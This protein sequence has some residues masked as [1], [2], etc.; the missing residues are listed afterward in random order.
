[1]LAAAGC[2]CAPSAPP[3][4][5]PQPP[6][7]ALLLVLDTT[8]D[9][10]L[11]EVQTPA[12]D[13]LAAAGARAGKAWPGGSWTVPSVISLFMGKPVRSHGW[14]QPSGLLGRYPPLPAFPTLAEV[15]HDAG[16]ST[17]G[18]Y[19]N[20]YLSEKL[21]FDRGFDG[22][23]RSGDAQIPGQLAAHV[24]GHWGDG[25]RHFAY[26]HLLGPHSPLRPSAAA[27]ARFG[28]DPA[29]F[30]GPHGLLIGAA[31]RDREGP[32][33]ATY[34]QAYRA[35]LEDS[36]ARVGEVL[37][38]L[39]PHRKD[40]LVVFTSDHGELLGEHDRVGHGHH[41]WE[42]LAAVPLVVDHPGIPGDRE[43]LA[44]AGSAVAIAD[45]ITRSLAVPAD[46]EIGIR[47]PL[48][49]VV[50][51]EGRVA[52]SP[53]GRRKAL[54]DSDL[55]EEPHIF[56]LLADPGEARPPRRRSRLGPGCHPRHLGGR[57]PRRPLLGPGR[58]R[59]RRA[60][61]LEGAGLSGRFAVNLR[62]LA[63]FTLLSAP[64]AA[65]G[66]ARPAAAPAPPRPAARSRP[67]RGR[68]PGARS[69]PR[70]PCPAAPGASP[71]PLHRRLPGQRPLCRGRAL[72]G[73]PPPRRPGLAGSAHAQAL[74]TL[75][76]ASR[77]ADP[78]CRSCH[79]TG[80]GHEGGFSTP[81]QKPELAHVQCEACHG[82]GSDHVAGP[83]AGYGQ[84]PRSLAACVACH[85][86]DRAPDFIFTDAWARIAH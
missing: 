61:C 40:T 27:L 15:L 20:P 49:L 76:T 45:L 31:K 50:Q 62:T 70:W 56:D 23:T 16:F 37:A 63:L 3:P 72:R 41:V 8:R 65:P 24:A 7:H 86:E 39:G 59:S 52:I 14:D 64:M 75:V 47:D 42:A 9:D 38:A 80:L 78:G 33:R 21:G 5:P 79:V 19:A 67:G 13:A 82:P 32:I 30:A 46:W 10:L 43:T 28:L 22:W 11:R 83:R 66:C 55:G 4:T 12:I 69:D 77:D 81:G 36:D 34:G 44:P 53:D 54:W 48:P 6:R 2:A 18:W 60:G 58:P 25:G 84:L 35:A 73:L 57:P 29:T 51:R 1:M 26:V 85:N 17:Q 74:F 68:R 71:P